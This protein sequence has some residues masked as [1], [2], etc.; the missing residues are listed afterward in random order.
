MQ[1]DIQHNPQTQADTRLW[2][3]DEADWAEPSEYAPA[4]VN[5]SVFTGSAVQQLKG[6]RQRDVVDVNW[7]T[8]NGLTKSQAAISGQHF[9]VTSVC[10]VDGGGVLLK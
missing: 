5:E 10:S 1:F 9:P 8:I 3:M 7:Q 4:S 2:T 6:F